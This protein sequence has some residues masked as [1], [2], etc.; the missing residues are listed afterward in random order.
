M[1]MQFQAEKFGAYFE[2]E[3]ITA[4][5][6]VSGGP[7]ILTVSD[8]FTIEDALSSLNTKAEQDGTLLFW[9]INDGELSLHI[10]NY[11]AEATEKNCV[12]YAFAEYVCSCSHKAFKTVDSEGGYGDHVKEGD[13]IVT[14][15]TCTE[16]GH[17]LYHCPLCDEDFTSDVVKAKGHSTTTVGKV[18]A[19]CVSK[20]YTGDKVCKVCS[21]TVSKGKDRN[22][23]GIHVWTNPKVTKEPTPD[24][25]GEVVYTCKHCSDTRSES[26]TAIGHE[27]GDFEYKDEDYH[28]ALCSCGDVITEEHNYVEK[29]V[30]REPTADTEGAVLYECTVCKGQK[31]IAVPSLGH[32]VGVWTPENETHHSGMCSCG[33][34]ERA[35]HSWD[36]GTVVSDGISD[37]SGMEKTL[38]VCTVCEYQR[39]T[40]REVELPVDEEEVKNNERIKD[41]ALIIL[42]VLLIGGISAWVYIRLTDRR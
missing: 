26:I 18:D 40:E 28:S 39:V 34:T 22:P 5:K 6:I 24:E 37:K 42:A 27:R 1:N 8:G 38:Y 33:L 19:T 2:Y 11:L 13:G 14:E 10:H 35:E 20:G 17:T 7:H 3:E 36:S 21:V 41:Y 4:V 23:T 31:E 29:G 30:V 12:S 15:P 9:E 32:F 16:E 25:D